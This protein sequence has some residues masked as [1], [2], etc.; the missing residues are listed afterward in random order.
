MANLLEAYAKRL[1]IAESVYSKAHDGA[2]MDNHRKLVT[3]RCL[4]NVNAY[5][6]EAFDNSVG[7]QRSD[8]GMFKKFALNLT[9][10]A[11]PN[12][13]A[14]DLVLVHPMTSMSGY[15]SYIKYTTGSEKG[16]MHNG[17]DGTNE[18]T[19]LFSPFKQ[20]KVSDARTNYTSSKVEIKDYEGEELAWAPIVPRSVKVVA[21]GTVYADLDGD[22]KLYEVDGSLA[23]ITDSYGNISIAGKKAVDAE[24]G[25]VK[26]SVGTVIYGDNKGVAGSVSISGDLTYSYNNVIVPQNDI[27]VLNAE[28]SAIP[29]MAKARRIAVYYS[30]IAA[31]QAKTDYGFDL[32]D[33]L[34]EKAVGELSY[35][36][37]T[38]VVNLLYKTA[39]EVTKEYGVDEALVWDRTLPTGV[40]K[41]EH[42]EGFSEV[43][44]VAGQYVYD[45]TQKFAPNYMV[46]ASNIVPI[47]N[48][49]KGWKAA[50]K[51]T[52]NGPYFAGTL[53]GLKVFVSPSIKSGDF[54]LGVNGDDLMTSAAVYAPY[55]PIV[56]TQLL[57][58]ADGGTSQGFSTLYDLKILNR[59]LLVAGHV[60]GAFGGVT[61]QTTSFKVTNA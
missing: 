25:V 56:P 39:Q 16:G 21:D 32:G 59:D 36:I 11:L 31:F 18:A 46:I 57:Q 6:T 38:E 40:S 43:I 3:A 55:M 28:L 58:Y 2:K 22:G 60:D 14:N 5:M 49:I 50:P 17:T 24:T 35:E 51:G 26:A 8:M 61:G 42:Y 10:V 7:T 13:I 4:Q 27:P 54:F 34:A 45:R 19:E 33:Q 20:G 47:L 9:T 44:G 53:D 12:L 1:T 52:V 29:L 48:F 37:D 30:Q 15:I 41:A 23:L